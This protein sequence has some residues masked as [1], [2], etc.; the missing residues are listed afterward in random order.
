MKRMM[1]LAAMAAAGV[2][3]AAAQTPLVDAA[4]GAGQVG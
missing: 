1:V 3:P 2:A 4:R